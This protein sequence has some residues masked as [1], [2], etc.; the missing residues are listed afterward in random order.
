MDILHRIKR[1]LIRGHF[2][3]SFKAAHEMDVDDLEE[4]D[5]VE[6]VM[7]ATEIAKT[8]RSSSPR[9]HG[10]KLYVIKGNTYDG[11]EIYTKGKITRDGDEEIYYF[12]VSSKRSTFGK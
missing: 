1:L 9:G 3:F 6:A 4:A 5:V 2:K 12:F 8:L 7:N 10:E 11:T